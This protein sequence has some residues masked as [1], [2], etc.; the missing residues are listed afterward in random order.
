MEK[1]EQPRPRVFVREATFGIILLVIQYVLGMIINLFIKFPASGPGEAWRFAWS[2]ITVAAHIILG[3][4]GFLMVLSMLIRSIVRKNRHWI[5]VTSLG[6]A[7]FALAVFGGETFITTQ[8]DFA[9]FVMAFGF[10]AAILVF[11]WGLFSA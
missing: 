3:T 4:A 11:S 7:A 6:T 9:S 5:L 2:N 10:L 1:M 8:N